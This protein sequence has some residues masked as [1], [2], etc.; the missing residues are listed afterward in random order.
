MQ[1]VISVLGSNQ[2]NFIAE[3]LP[4]IS[5]CKCSLLEIRCSQL[6]QRVTA[7]YV[8]VQGNWN[9]IA[10]LESVLEVLQR[11]MEI[12]I[13]TMRPEQKEKNREFL[14]YTLETMSLTT[15]NIMES[16]TTFLLDREIEIEE[17]VGSSYPAPY[18]HTPVFSC[19]CVILIPPHLNLFA[20]RE[21]F[22]DLCDQVNI[23]AILE[24]LK[25]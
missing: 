8:L 5:D 9:Q 20:L 23:Y 14:P 3:L 17:M 19:K 22:L 18:V 7:V 16:V 6:A 1:L 13:H 10:K 4:A 24:P 21:E 11:R 2:V 12:K 25:R 15:H